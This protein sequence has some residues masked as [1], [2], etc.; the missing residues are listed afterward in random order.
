MITPSAGK[1][2]TTIEKV[3]SKWQMVTDSNNEHLSGRIFFLL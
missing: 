2:P 1:Q 3:K